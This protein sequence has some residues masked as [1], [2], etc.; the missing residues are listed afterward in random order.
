MLFTDS[1]RQLRDCAREFVDHEVAPFAERWERER[2]FPPSLFAQMGERGLLGLAQEPR[3]GGRGLEFLHDVVLAEEMTRSRMLGLCLSVVAQENIFPPLLARLGTPE[4]K[5]HFLKPANQGLKIG[6]IASTEPSGGSDIVRAI[7]CT[8][9]E[10]GDSWIISGEKKYITNAPIADFIICIVRTRPERATSSLSLVIVP[11]ETPGLTIGTL[12]KLGMHTSPT[13]WLKFDRC[14]VP[15][16]LTLGRPNLG[17]FYV[18]RNILEERLIGGVSSVAVAELTLGETLS[19]LRSRAAFGGTLADLQAIRH[20]VSEMAAE[21]E[22]SRRF[23][24]SV[25]E[26]YN[27]GKVEER[28]ICMIKFRVFELVQK[29]VEQCVQFHGGWGYM[30]DNWLTRVYRDVRMLSV[31]GGP[32]ELMKDV[33]AAYMRL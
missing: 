26:N 27:I 4:Q 2:G 3:Y 21:I 33:V 13:G 18:A 22:C 24:Y 20:R 12:S 7:G 25:C 15:R 8:A 1:H 31:G 5:D 17:Y 10:D 29:V 14:R 30:D 6:C 28:E 16:T 23:V 19:Y 32:S 11:R 9:V